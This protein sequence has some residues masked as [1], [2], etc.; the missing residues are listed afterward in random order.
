MTELHDKRQCAEHEIRMTDTTPEFFWDYWPLWRIRRLR[1]LVWSNQL[2]RRWWFV[3]VFSN[4]GNYFSSLQT[5][6][7][8][9]MGVKLGLRV[10]QN[11]A[12][13]QRKWQGYSRKVD[14]DELHNLNSSLKWLKWF[15]DERISNGGRQ[16]HRNCWF[17]LKGRH[18]LRD[19]HV[20]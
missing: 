14:N 20:D 1:R 3:I 15:N 19:L 12:L 17:I 11:R 6:T 10:F 8:L 2:S 18:Y 13:R 9:Y 16:K 4:R 5:K 7:V